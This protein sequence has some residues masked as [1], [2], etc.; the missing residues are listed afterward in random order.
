MRHIL[1]ALGIALAVAGCMPGHT[2]SPLEA[3]QPFP[4]AF[5]AAHVVSV[6]NALIGNR[7]AGI[8]LSAGPAPIGLIGLHA[9][10]GL[11][12][13]SGHVGVAAI[14][15]GIGPGIEAPASALEYTVALDQDQSPCA[16]PLGRCSPS[17]QIVQISQ[18]ILPEDMTPATPNGFISPGQPALV[19][20]VDHIA[21]VVPY[22]SAA[23]SGIPSNFNGNII[24]P[25]PLLPSGS[26]WSAPRAPVY[27][28][29]PR[30]LAAASTYPLYPGP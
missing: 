10:P 18:Q 7:G 12:P 27:A 26:A 8:G 24:S 28:S 9:G 1:Y 13:V 29:P 6:Q 20:V 15:V 22:I 23:F 30:G 3:N 25:P 2:Y 5:Y 14:G 11:E 17:S 19:R 4:V 21:R 16:A